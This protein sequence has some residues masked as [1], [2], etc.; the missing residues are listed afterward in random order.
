MTTEPKYKYE[1]VRVLRVLD[2]DT[3]ELEIDLG[4]NLRWV[5]K[6]RLYGVDAP[7]TH[8]ETKP[9][10]EAAADKLRSLL[11]DGVLLAQTY[12]P[13]KYGRWLV[14]L[15]VIVGA[16]PADVSDAMIS[17]GHARPYFGGKK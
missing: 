9:A 3:V 8:G 4:N 12:K 11:A 13:D 1:N 15:T 16:Y 14:R 7:E 10:G 2:G 17:A 6:F 5:D